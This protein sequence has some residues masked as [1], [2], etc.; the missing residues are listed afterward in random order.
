MNKRTALN[1]FNVSK[2]FR[3]YVYDHVVLAWE[4]DQVS[5]TSSDFS[6]KVLY[7]SIGLRVEKVQELSEVE[8]HSMFSWDADEFLIFYGRG[9]GY[10]LL[11]KRL[12]DSF[13]HGDYGLDE[14]GFIKIWHRYKS[15][16]EKSENTRLVARLRQSKLKQLINFLGRSGSLK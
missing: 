6:K 2:A 5:I 12:R 1:P 11:F 10:Q 16:N 4:L 8:R 13:A 14:R 9:Q 15:P 3:N 7:N